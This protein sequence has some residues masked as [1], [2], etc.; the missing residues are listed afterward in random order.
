M[1]KLFKKVFGKKTIRKTQKRIDRLV[2]W[3]NQFGRSKQC[4]VC[5]RRFHRFTKYKGGFKNRPEYL[6]RLEMVGS[7]IDNFYCM[8]CGAHDRERHLFMYFDRLKIWPKLKGARIL[9]FAPERHLPIK[10][11]KQ[12]PLESIKADLHPS[13]EGVKKIDATHIPFGD[14]TFDFLIANHILEH[15]PDYRMA[16]A[17]F[18]R[19]LKPGGMAVLQTPFSKILKNNF[20]DVNL[21][22]DELRRFFYGQE[23]H[24]R[25][26]G[27]HELFESIKD[28]G[29]VLQ[30]EKHDTLF[31]AKMADRYGV[32]RKEDFILSLKPPKK[33]IHRSSQIVS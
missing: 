19:V 23:D 24:V 13:S 33:Q 16:L 17:E 9:H 20:E 6:H 21:A 18:F 14:D 3:L 1:N 5:K 26:F 11:S 15:I 7:D 12:S 4:Y 8:Y 32:N 22:T 30:I 29:F 27:G 2:K 25:I 31:N 10:I 28:A